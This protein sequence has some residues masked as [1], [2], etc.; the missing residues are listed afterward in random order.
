MDFASLQ[1]QPSKSKETFFFSFWVGLICLGHLA[2]YAN[3]TTSM[4]RLN[5]IQTL[6]SR[7]TCCHVNKIFRGHLVPEAEAVEV[8]AWNLTSW[9]LSHENVQKHG[10]GN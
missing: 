8:L 7:A 4:G 5:S 1:V 6:Q 2:R 3:S 9:K 10:I